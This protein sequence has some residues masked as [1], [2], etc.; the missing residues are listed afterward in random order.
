MGVCQT[1]GYLVGGPHTRSIISWGSYWGP[2]T[3]GNYHMTNVM[4]ILAIT[5]IISMII[6]IVFVVITIPL[7]KSGNPVGLAWGLCRGESLLGAS[8]EFQR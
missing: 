5:N 2:L 4:I 1:K 8:A 7:V 3:Q 6:T